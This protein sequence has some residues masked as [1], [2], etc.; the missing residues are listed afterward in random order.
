MMDKFIKVEKE[1]DKP[2]RTGFAHYIVHIIALSVGFTVG[3]YYYIFS[4]LKLSNSN[5]RTV[6]E[7][8]RSNVSIAIDDHE[9]LMIIDKETGDYTIYQDSVGVSIFNL[10]AK[11][12]VSTGSSNP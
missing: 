9:N 1:L 5:K 3:Y 7:I 8:R 2:K 10:Y 6:K 4:E 11:N 12:I